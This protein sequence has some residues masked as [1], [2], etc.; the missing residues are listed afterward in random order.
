MINVVELANN[1][2]SIIHV[3][4]LLD[5]RADYGIKLYCPFG[6]MYHRDDGMSPAM[7]AYEETNTVNCFAGCGRF[8]SVSLY[9]RAKGLEW[10]DAADE[11]LDL[12][13][14]DKHD[15]VKR[16]ERVANYI[17][18]IDVENLSSALQI[19]C[20]RI[21]QDWDDD[22]FDPVVS[23]KLSRCLDLLDRVTTQEDAVLWLSTCKAVMS[24]V[25]SEYH[26]A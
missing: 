3:L 13:G 9:A 2:V 17:P 12:I 23:V 6:R 1:K 20:E 7:R 15:V 5:V 4:K 19:Y 21:A 10:R 14:Y 26:S 8:D 16:W 22:Q 11:L 24:R 25:L 18:E